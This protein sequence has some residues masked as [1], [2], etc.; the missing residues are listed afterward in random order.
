M[1]GKEKSL[2]TVKCSNLFCTVPRIDAVFAQKRRR[3]G[4]ISLQMRYFSLGRM[5]MDGL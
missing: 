2:Y 3:S 1:H 5:S 4:T